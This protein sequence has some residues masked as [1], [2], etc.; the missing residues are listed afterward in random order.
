[1]KVVARV[2]QYQDYEAMYR[3]M[4]E[5]FELLG[6][7]R[8]DERDG[9]LFK[10]SY[11]E[12]ISCKDQIIK[13]QGVEIADLKRQLAS[14]RSDEAD[15]DGAV[16]AMQNPR[17]RSAVNDGD[18][19]GAAAGAEDEHA[20]HQVPHSEQQWVDRVD[21]LK[22]EH[23]RALE[24]LKSQHSISLMKSHQSELR[25]KQELITAQVRTRP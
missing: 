8:K 21:S 24:S 2:S 4:K 12:I 22:A 1:V 3:E 11:V 10:E 23:A 5:Q 25:S 9:E 16:S 6:R 14:F 17:M 18:P 7:Q 20:T 15:P 13:Q 19:R